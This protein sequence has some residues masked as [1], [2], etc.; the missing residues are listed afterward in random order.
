MIF[1]TGAY[2][3][4]QTENSE[5]AY[6]KLGSPVEKHNVLAAE[7]GTNNASIKS[8]NQSGRNGWQLISSSTASAYLNINID[9]KYAFEVD[10]GTEY[11]VEVDYFDIDNAVFNLKYD[12]QDNP[13]KEEENI[14]LGTSQKWKTAVFILKDAYFGNRLDGFDMR[15]GVRADRIPRSMGNVTVSEIRISRSDAKNPVMIKVNSDALGNIFGNGEEKAL[16]RKLKA[17][18]K[19]MKPWMLHILRM[20]KPRA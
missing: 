18:Q 8:V 16:Q 10:D 11:T 1:G 12:S 17:M 14:Y 6:V 15:I 19:K 2:A 20:M 5:I 9:D 13:G 4:E 3:A 7:M